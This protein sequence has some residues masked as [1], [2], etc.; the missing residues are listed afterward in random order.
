MDRKPGGLQSMGL[1]ESMRL[2]ES[3]RT[4]PTHTHTHSEHTHTH[5]EHAH[6]HTEHAHTH[7]HTCTHRVSLKVIAVYAF[8]SFLYLIVSGLR[9][10]MLSKVTLFCHLKYLA[11]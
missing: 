3:S 10:M 8:I 7:T 11:W 5:T 2:H 6:T 4:E 1:Q 9:R